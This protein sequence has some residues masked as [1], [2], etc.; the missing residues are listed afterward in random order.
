[1]KDSN[2]SGK[3]YVM[4]EIDKSGKLICQIKKGSGSDD[5]DSDIK[6]IIENSGE[7]VPGEYQNKNVG[8]WGWTIP[9]S[10]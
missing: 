9:I 1:M 6:Q 8:V 4:I 10:I 5:V 2:F 3:I 7:F